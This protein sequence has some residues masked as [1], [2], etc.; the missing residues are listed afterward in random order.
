[1][2]S[3]CHK[4]ISMV[5]KELQKN[6]LN[7]I[8]LDKNSNRIDMINFKELKKGEDS[9]KISIDC[10]DFNIIKKVGKGSYGSVFLVQN[11]YSKSYYAMK[12]MCKEKIKK[13]DLV[14]N[15]KIERILLSML[16]HPFIV[17]LHFS[18]QSSTK[19]YLVTEYIS[20]GDLFEQQRRVESY[21]EEMIKIYIAE[22]ILA[23]EYLHK[24][25]CIYRDLKPENILICNDG[26]IKLVDFNL[27]KLFLSNENIFDNK[28]ESLCGTADYMAPEILTENKYDFTVDF[29]S[30]GILMYNL[31]K[32]YTPL[33]CK[34]NHLDIS[35][36]KQEVYYD[37]KTFSKEAKSLISSLIEF[38]PKKRIG[39]T[40]IKEI[41]DHVYFKD[42]DFDKIFNK[43]YKIDS[44][45]IPL[46]PR[47]SITNDMNNLD[48][49]KIMN[50][51]EFDE[52]VND[53]KFKG[54]T[55]NGFT[56]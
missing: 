26:H 23:L 56:S 28:A 32:G 43:L 53:N 41:K 5:D 52:S 39:K 24:N 25:N 44:N 48:N 18:F 33:N 9:D 7:K 30:L 14:E 47:T 1:M 51:E 8:L 49:N 13:S 29:Y 21:R 20:G 55:Y 35:N 16:N 17:E 3:I 45:L 4:N 42:I 2:G 37:D 6:C 36:K 46:E 12:V 50:L 31:Y 40:G 38:N 11:K 34:K 27:S 10:N 22:L 15:T 19:L 54:N